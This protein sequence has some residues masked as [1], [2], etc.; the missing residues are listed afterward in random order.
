MIIKCDG[1]NKD[2]EI[3]GLIGSPQHQFSPLKNFCS[4]VCLITTAEKY[5]KC[6]SDQTTDIVL[7]QN[8]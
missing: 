4:D 8:T 6:E 1:C 3:Q 7:R 5:R 2:I